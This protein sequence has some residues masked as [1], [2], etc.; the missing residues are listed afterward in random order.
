MRIV[1][2]GASTN[3]HDSI[4]STAPEDLGGTLEHHGDMLALGSRS[5]AS[6]RSIY[7]TSTNQLNGETMKD[8]LPPSIEDLRNEAE[9]MLRRLGFDVSRESDAWWIAK[10]EHAD[11]RIDEYGVC[12]RTVPD[13]PLA[14][15]GAHFHFGRFKNDMSEQSVD[16]SPSAENSSGQTHAWLVA[17]Y[18]HDLDAQVA[19]I[20]L[21]FGLR[22]KLEPPRMYRCIVDT[23][24][25]DRMLPG[26]YI[27]RKVIPIGAIGRK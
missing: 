16:L 2:R 24:P 8:A 14:H 12:V 7:V 17:W 5:C 11:G 10:C 22:S 23:R 13:Q 26:D 20:Q 21:T 15:D 9:Q 4:V 27:A 18:R 6:A 25:L 19:E 3:P 1:S